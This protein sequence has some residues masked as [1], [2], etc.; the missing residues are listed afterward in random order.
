MISSILAWSPKTCYAR[1]L[2][3]AKGGKKSLS[4]FL[5]IL[6]SITRTIESVRGC[7]NSLQAGDTHVLKGL[8]IILA[9]CQRSTDLI[10]AT[11]LTQPQLTASLCSNATPSP[12][13]TRSP[14]SSL[15]SPLRLPLTP[16]SDTRFAFLM[17]L[18]FNIEDSPSQR[19]PSAVRSCV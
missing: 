19:M 13:T 7:Y 1:Q 17:T 6:R 2:S 12:P 11:N 16:L 4:L 5:G 18:G 10:L 8:Q 15:P 3:S 14:P 9:A